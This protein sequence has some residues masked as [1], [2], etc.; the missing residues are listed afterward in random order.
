M[1]IRKTNQ[2]MYDEI[3]DRLQQDYLLFED[4]I[5]DR[6]SR[7]ET[8]YIVSRLRGAMKQARPPFEYA[9]THRPVPL[10]EI[11]PA[12][13]L[14]VMAADYLSLQ[15]R[16]KLGEVF[17]LEF[18]LKYVWEPT[19]HYLAP[20]YEQSEGVPSLLV[21]AARAAGEYHRIF[22]KT[23]GFPH[24]RSHLADLH[25]NHKHANVILAAA[26]RATVEVT[27]VQERALEYADEA[28]TRMNRAMGTTDQ[29]G[30]TPLQFYTGSIHSIPV[31]ASNGIMPGT[32]S[33]FTEQ[34]RVRYTISPRGQKCENITQVLEQFL[35]NVDKREPFEVCWAMSPK[36]SMEV[37]FEEQGSEDQFR[38][39][40]A[41]H[42]VFII[43]SAPFILAERLT[44]YFS[45]L[46]EQNTD[47]K[48]GFKWPRGGADYLFKGFNL[49]GAL[50]GD[51]DFSKLDQTIHQ[52]LMRLFYS[53]RFQYNCDGSDGD[54]MRWLLEQIVRHVTVRLTHL[55]D[56]L[57][58]RVT[59]QM[60]SG[61]WCTSHG[62]SWIVM[63]LFYLFVSCKLAVIED[64]ELLLDI[65]RQFRERRIGIIVYGDDHVIITTDL[66]EELLGEKSFKQWVSQV[67][68]MTIRKE[69]T[70]LPLLTTTRNGEVQQAG[71]VFLKHYLIKNFLTIAGAPEMLPFRPK[72][73]VA[74]R[75]IWGNAGADRNA[76][77]SLLTTLGLAYGLM[78][79]NPEL[80]EWLGFY[81]ETLSSAI[82][83][84]DTKAWAGAYDR[85][86]WRK[87][88]S[89]D[90]SK[91]VLE[92]GYPSLW[93]VQERNRKDP[94][95]HT[96][97]RNPE[98]VHEEM[99]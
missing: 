1:D 17:D 15:S 50:F 85:F 86:N 9:P 88:R 16:S 13:V 3:F 99:W 27:P 43:P 92:R 22:G 7:T 29:V 53:S 82:E 98:E 66:S 49:K 52:I 39:W 63:F 71:V 47:I 87:F 28:I 51:G 78:G 6:E 80:H 55:M 93:V 14:S 75:A 34:G 54:V 94:A 79:T 8:E 42:R 59:G 21:L 5:Y 81:Y 96:V 72:S 19:D 48:I 4:G 41:K 83:M 57:W 11:A 76:Y 62:D 70:R 46:V 64:E 18:M 44:C 33:K 2:Q 45:K 20:Q 61:A 37:S 69:R 73:E 90:V 65:E 89:Y 23:N 25:E 60:P 10:P 36:S 77:D 68:G 67:W 97:N 26:D 35:K 31:H 58:A 84:N 56:K 95:Y 74:A 40:C 12:I 38:A 30:K 24:V 91:D 32:V